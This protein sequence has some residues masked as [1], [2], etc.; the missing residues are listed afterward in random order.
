MAAARTAYHVDDVAAAVTKFTVADG[1]RV[2][3][4]A[5]A[6]GRIGPRL[7]RKSVV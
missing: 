3:V 6:T 4:S 5:G 2:A 7:D 1:Q